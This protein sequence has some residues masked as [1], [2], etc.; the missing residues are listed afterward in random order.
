MEVDSADFYDDLDGKD[1]SFNVSVE[2]DYLYDQ[3][4]I[5]ED[6]IPLIFCD[7]NIP[8][9]Q[10]IDENF[11]DQY[12]TPAVKSEKNSPKQNID[13]EKTTIE[14]SNS[15][16][17]HKLHKSKIAASNFGK[18]SKCQKNPDALMTTLIYDVSCISKALE[19]G[20][21]HEQ[22]AIKAYVAA[23]KKVV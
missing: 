16:V 17:W 14:Q 12:V 9:S 11:I 10:P 2:A 15:M 7:K 23:K 8:D 4:E 13:I 20:K 3:P 1:V 21:V 5:I 6:S 18:V 19:Y 22:D